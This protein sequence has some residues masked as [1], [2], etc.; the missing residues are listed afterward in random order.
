MRRRPIIGALLLIGVGVV[1]GTTVFRDDIAQAAGLAGSAPVTV[2]NTPDQAVPTREQNTDGSGAIKV[3]EQGTASVSGTVGLSA[4]ANT[5]KLDPAANTVNLGTTDSGKLSTADSH[6]SSIDSATGQFRFDGGGNL[7]VA[8]QGTQ[9]VHVDN[10]SLSVAGPAP[11]Q[12]LIFNDGFTVP[13]DNA[14]HEVASFKVP[15]Y[16]DFISAGG[17]TGNQLLTFQLGTTPVLFLQGSVNKGQES[18]VLNLTHPVEF[19]NVQAACANA[20]NCLIGV[21]ISGTINP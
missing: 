21:S 1:L 4:S 15:L 5:V 10:T 2:L 9:T 11:T 13:N 17:M 6:L 19:D 16:A 12:T 14:N 18:W 7:K 3:H 8:P 20:S